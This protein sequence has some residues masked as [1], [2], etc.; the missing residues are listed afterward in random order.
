MEDQDNS[1]NGANPKR[2]HLR[3]RRV[4][5]MQY[6]QKGVIDDAP[7]KER[8]SREFKNPRLKQIKAPEL[9]M[10]E[11]LQ[12][13]G[14]VLNVHRRTCVV[15]LNVAGGAQE[16]RAIYRATAIEELGEFPAVGDQVVVG[17]S[18]EDGDYF[19][20]RVLPRRSAL[21]RPGSGDRANQQFTQA[22]N[23]DQVVIV[24]SVA[25][26]EFNYGFADRFL[27]AAATSDLPLI[28]VLNK[29][30]L[31]TAVPE[32][33]LDFA[34]LVQ[35]LIP[36]SCVTGQGLAELREI[37]VGKNSVFSGQS[38]VGKSSL[39]NLLVP[40]A[41]LLTGEVRAKDGKGRHTTTSSSLFNL[42]GGGTVIDTPGIRALGLIDYEPADLARSFPGF[43]PEGIFTC[44][45]ND[46][47][48]LEEPGCA[49]QAAIETG[50]IPLQR[51]ASY[52][53]I[54]NADAL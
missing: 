18:D 37:L 30:D 8:W 45:F 52:H 26:P 39:V 24:C 17:Q 11:A 5:A 46:C 2:R 23:I 38:G 22:A 10:P 41:E 7:V 54:L 40:E 43:F 33:I 19:L 49:V 42:T 48:H 35:G 13:Q 6:W 1:Q 20:L 12:Q 15:R 31:V 21:E 9:N 50:A 53:R 3:N 51:W 14:L 16:V 27:L 32:H 47:L 29:M 34:Q 28:M 25:Q 4:N 36:V 44:K